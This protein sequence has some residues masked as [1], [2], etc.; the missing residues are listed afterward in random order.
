M[1]LRYLKQRLMTNIANRTFRKNPRFL[2][3]L[4]IKLLART[5]GPIQDDHEREHPY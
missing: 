1:K 3:R 4:A 5:K 2:D